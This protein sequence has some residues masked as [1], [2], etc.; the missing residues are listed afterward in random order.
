[1]TLL[2]P[3]LK[4]FRPLISQKSAAFAQGPC[5]SRE[6]TGVDGNAAL[7]D[8]FLRCAV[9]RA[10]LRLAARSERF[11]LKEFRHCPARLLALK[12]KA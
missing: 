4:T 5:F 1:M 9:T 11:P 3:S 12:G 10:P 6:T 2:L 8:F 7:F